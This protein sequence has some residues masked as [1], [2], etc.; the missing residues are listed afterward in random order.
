MVCTRPVIR[1]KKR[2]TADTKSLPL[3]IDDNK[4]H[5][6]TYDTTTGMV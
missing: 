5:S 2:L 3:S 1:F 4:Y 6:S